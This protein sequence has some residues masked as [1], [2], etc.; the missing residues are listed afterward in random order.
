VEDIKL[1]LAQVYAAEGKRDQALKV[2][3]EARDQA[4]ANKSILLGQIS[5]ELTKLESP[6]AAAPAQPDPVRLPTNPPR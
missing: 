6:A 5:Q 2:L 1:Q 4:Q 3:R